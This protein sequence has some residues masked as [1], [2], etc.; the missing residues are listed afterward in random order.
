MSID[1]V[2]EG[3][4]QV[5]KLSNFKQ[6]ESMFRPRSA[7]ISSTSSRES[8]TRDGFEVIDV[9][10]VI[11]FIFEIKLAGIGISIVNKRMQELAYTSVRDL[12][13]KFTDST[14][15]QSVR[16]VVKWLQV[17]SFVF[18]TVCFIWNIHASLIN[19]FSV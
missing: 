3:P 7:S 8:S 17:R 16:A 9:H 6:S 4:T 13:L 5:L 14:M 2:A 11:N 12:D 1:V 19:E 15:Y 18:I 10:S